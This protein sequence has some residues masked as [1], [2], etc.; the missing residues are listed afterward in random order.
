MLSIRAFGTRK[1]ISLVGG[2]RGPMQTAHTSSVRAWLRSDPVAADVPWLGDSM[3]PLIW[4]GPLGA[5]I[6]IATVGDGFAAHDQA[7]YNKA[8]DDLLTN[9]LFEEDFFRANRTAFNLLRINLVSMDSGVGTKTYD[10]AGNIVAQ[11]DRNTALGSYY[12]GDWA[13][14]WVEDGPDT[15]TRLSLALSVWAPDRR[16]VLVLQNNPGFGGCGGGGRATLPLGVT[17][18]TIAHE[19]GHALGGLADE[20][21][22]D[23]KTY[24]GDEPG[25]PNVTVNTDRPSLKW[26]WAVRATTPLPTGADDYTP[27]KPAGWDDNQDIGLFEGGRGSFQHGVYR[28]VVNCRMNS[29]T[30]PFCPVCN[31]AMSAITSPF[32]APAPVPTVRSAN[33]EALMA[34]TEALMETDA[35]DRYVRLQVRVD[36]EGLRIVDAREIPG[37]LVQPDQVASGMAHE[38]LIGGRRVAVGS[39]PDAAVVRSFSEIGPEGPREHHTYPLEEYEFAIRVPESELRGEDLSRL[40][41]N[42]VSVQGSRRDRLADVPMENDPAVDVTSI[43]S[44]NLAEASVPNSLR[45]ILGR[46]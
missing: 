4:N 18:S 32:L 20:Y 28:P 27:P 19:F 1:Q 3:T 30:P 35:E 44:A 21:H 42:V 39:L 7:A 13:H 14:C 26:G 34:N 5:E 38:L 25:E 16:L 8:V 40:T 37:P 11:T 2:I 29:N 36:R 33:M 43:T 12:N 6:T 31:A 41:V 23:N 17:W 24:G 9:G 22:R 15:S 46:T 45:H 10:A